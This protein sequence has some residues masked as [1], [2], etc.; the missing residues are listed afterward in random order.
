[1]DIGFHIRLSALALSE[2]G[3]AK[4]WYRALFFARAF[5]TRFK[6]K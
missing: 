2:N 4:D 5:L 3:D 6:Q 1:M